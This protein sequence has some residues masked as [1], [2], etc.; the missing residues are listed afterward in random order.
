MI[1]KF[2]VNSSQNKLHKLLKTNII[3]LNI[4][5]DFNYKFRSIKFYS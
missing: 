5:L 2:V 1:K 4:S 3:R